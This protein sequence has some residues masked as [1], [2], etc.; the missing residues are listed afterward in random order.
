MHELSWLRQQ[1]NKY[2]QLSVFKDAGLAN[3]VSKL[4][5][6]RAQ[7][8][9]TQAQ[10]TVEKTKSQSLKSELSSAQTQ[11]AGLQELNQQLQ[12]QVCVYEASASA[13]SL[14]TQTEDER[15]E[16]EMAA[17]KLKFGEAQRENH[18]LAMQLKAAECGLAR[19]AQLE[20]DC[21]SADQELRGKNKLLMDAEA[22]LRGLE[23]KLQRYESEVG[24]GSQKQQ[25]V[26]KEALTEVGSIRGLWTIAWSMVHT[27]SYVS[28]ALPIAW[29]V[30]SVMPYGPVHGM[31]PAARPVAHSMAYWP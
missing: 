24:D 2:E 16:R 7:Q 13:R 6:S 17:L 1:V 9:E 25:P 22:K 30:V 14:A 23:K 4:S 29:P 12:R 11:I 21:A 20:I 5:Q 15:Q 18:N 27:V 26:K 10:L 8:Q 3:V 19:L 28:L 31:W